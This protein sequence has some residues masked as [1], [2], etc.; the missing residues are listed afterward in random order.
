M[1]ARAPEMVA[2][3]RISRAPWRCYG[4]AIPRVGLVVSVLALSRSR[5][6][7]L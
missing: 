5:E 2:A 3:E 6:R 4:A 7:V 1:A